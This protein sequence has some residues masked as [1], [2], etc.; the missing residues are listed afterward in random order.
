MQIEIII[1]NRNIN[2][3]ST[4]SV[5]QACEGAGYTIPRFCYHE[6]LSV[7]G[8]CRMCLVEI[9][10]SPK[11]V[12][13]CAMPVSKGMVIFTETPLVKKARES[14]LEF[15]LVNHP[16]DCPICDQGGECDLQDETMQFGSDRGRYYDIKRCIEDKECGPIIKTIMNRCIHCTRCIRF[17]S[18][19]AGQNVLGAFG[20]GE[21]TEIGTYIQHFIKTELAGNLVDL[22]PVGAL[23]SKPYASSARSWELQHI[24]TVDFF[25]AMC[26][27]I[28]IHTRIL[29]STQ[30]KATTESLNTEDHILRIVPKVGGL[31]EE[32]WISDRT[33]HAFDGLL[34]QSLQKTNMHW[35]DAINTVR[36]R[37]ET[38]M[39]STSLQ[40][41]SVGVT[42]YDTANCNKPD[43]VN[44]AFGLDKYSSIEPS[45]KRDPNYCR[46]IPDSIK[47]GKKPD[48]TWPECTCLTPD[49]ANCNKPDCTWPECTCLTPDTA[50]CKK[51]D[52]TWPECTCL[53]PDIADCNK[54]SIGQHYIDSDNDSDD[55]WMLVGEVSDSDDEYS[56]LDE[57]NIQDNEYFFEQT[58]SDS[59]DEYS[60]LDEKNIEDKNVANLIKQYK[61]NLIDGKD[62]L[63]AI[64][65]LIKKVNESVSAREKERGEEIKREKEYV[66]TFGIKPN[67]PWPGCS[68]PECSCPT[69]KTDNPNLSL[70]TN[71]KNIADKDVANLIKQYKLNPIDDKAILDVIQVLI[72]KK[73]PQYP[74]LST[75]KKNSFD[76]DVGCIIELNSHFWTRCLEYN[77][78]GVQKKYSRYQEHIAIFSKKTCIERT[79]LHA[80]YMQGWIQKSIRDAKD[81]KVDPKYRFIEPLH[82]DDPDYIRKIPEN[83]IITPAEMA[84]DAAYLKWILSNDKDKDKVRWDS[85]KVINYIWTYFAHSFDNEVKMYQRNP[86]NKEYL[87]KKGIRNNN[88]EYKYQCLPGGSL[89]FA[90]DPYILAQNQLQKNN[91]KTPE[92]T[93][94][95]NYWRTDTTASA[96]IIEQDYVEYFGQTALREDLKAYFI[97]DCMQKW[98]CNSMFEYQTSRT[99]ILIG[100]ICGLQEIYLLNQF[101]KLAGQT[102]IQS[103]NVL[104]KLSYDHTTLFS[105]N[106][107]IESLKE[108]ETL[109]IVGLNTRY[110]AS[111]LNTFLRKH[112][113]Q[114]ALTYFYVGAN[115]KLQLNI[116]HYGNSLR[117]LITLT[118][119]RIRTTFTCY[120]SKNT[121]IFYG[122]ESL[123]IQSGYLFQNILR[124]LGKKLYTKTKQGERLGVVHANI[125]TLSVA[126]LGI[127]SGVRS[128]LYID[129]IEDKEIATFFTIQTHDIKEKKWLSVKENTYSIALLSNKT[130]TMP[131]YN[132]VLPIQSLYEK[133]GYLFNIEGR[134]RKHDKA[135]SPVQSR[136]VESF[137]A[138]LSILTAG[139]RAAIWEAIWK[140]NADVSIETQH[141]KVM[142]N[143]DFN[144]FE[145]TTEET[146]GALFLFAP[147]VTNYFL[148]DIISLNSPVMGKC[149]LFLKNNTWNF[150]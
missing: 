79:E 80:V 57:K 40:E 135:I 131:R 28:I 47:A 24:N 120:L 142:F 74:N 136:S 137:F 118:E 37:I 104:P 33:R 12:V 50:N 144:I 76:I 87:N 67:C 130:P 86:S 71:E 3:R 38:T 95:A 112:Q 72:K 132:T 65:M 35:I 125:A 81:A 17:S 60:D 36:K 53:T 141:E 84:R 29:S 82:K 107:T 85:V 45:H 7:A 31:Y 4:A 62:P 88:Y 49:T 26:S 11:P 98:I 149:S 19:I 146:K 42:G 48:C 143:F 114:R 126:Q 16:L 117:S 100:P 90:N 63:D 91:K 103:G 20:R 128:P 10:K 15:L 66:D 140:F 23:T 69:S 106:R 113:L 78:N 6:Q 54:T 108:L 102:D 121:S 129:N 51:P 96:A 115:A 97:Q 32:N 83:K 30:I 43:P 68:W 92:P 46:T 56:D 73:Y 25:D 77:Q 99:A 14:V 5:L 89:C 119:N 124:F 9:Q 70:S 44:E 21:N 94:A 111:L 127:T 39:F 139:N 134:L 147:I 22:C 123:R 27:D 116:N 59:D 122:F 1:N 52:C 105:L 61:L 101:S 8:N 150:E 34:N 138:A 64:L 58:Y 110:E 13:S 145:L 2:V 41:A 93:K 109:I 55:D 148:N 133:D 75:N 18:E